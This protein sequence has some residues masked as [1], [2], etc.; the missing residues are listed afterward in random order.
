L[1]AEHIPDVAES[2][3]P[4]L[5][6]AEAARCRAERD[7][8]KL[9]ICSRCH[10]NIPESELA[11]HMLNHR[12]KSHGFPSNPKQSQKPTAT[13]PM[14]FEEFSRRMLA[15]RSQK[16][17]LSPDQVG[18]IFGQILKEM[19][20]PINSLKID[21][22]RRIQAEVLFDERRNVELN[23]D[24]NYFRTLSEDEI[25]ATLSH[26]ACHIATLPDS[27]VIVMSSTG[28]LQ[29]SDPFQSMQMSFIELYDEFLAH[30][31][32]ARRFRGTDT[33]TLYDRIKDGDFNNYSII[34][35][36]ARSGLADATNAIILI[37][38]DAVYF[39]LIGDSRFL[40][41]CQDNG[42]LS[43]A[44]FLDWLVED[45][46][47]IEG[48]NLDRMETMRTVVQEGVLS[49][50]VDAAVM[51]AQDRVVFASS[52]PEAESTMETRNRDLAVRWRERR[53]AISS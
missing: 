31:E 29:L 12:G 50:G 25:R 28:S 36:T 39:P 23:Y 7:V 9:V 24:D 48:L 27:N 30:K 20:L 52:A 40:K 2:S 42:L 3:P 13:I 44:L 37:L 14:A 4:T 11:S 16:S 45:F 21:V 32:F 47:F 33:F 41:W 17:N 38:N 53:L 22:K 18:E 43:V 1:I 6:R 51:L 15:S 19:G 35:K 34:L 5:I 26:E 10:R 49:L 46:R 8:S